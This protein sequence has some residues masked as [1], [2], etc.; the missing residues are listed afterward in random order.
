MRSVRSS[1]GNS[2]CSVRAHG[3]D[4]D[5]RKTPHVPSQAHRAAIAALA[6]TQTQ[7]SRAMLTEPRDLPAIIEAADTVRRAERR[8]MAV[9]RGQR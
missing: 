8:V 9:E 7:L 1:E 3:R 2:G 5:N 4:G 6:D